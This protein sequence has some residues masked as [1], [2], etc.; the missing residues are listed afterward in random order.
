MDPGSCPWW[1]D[2]DLQRTGAVWVIV[3][4]GHVPVFGLPVSSRRGMTYEARKSE[5]LAMLESTETASRKANAGSRMCGSFALIVNV[6]VILAL[7][8][9]VYPHDTSRQ[10]GAASEKPPNCRH[11]AGG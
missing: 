1:P 4:I 8:S 6:I 10:G 7:A 11:M 9:A 3:T 5:S 2:E